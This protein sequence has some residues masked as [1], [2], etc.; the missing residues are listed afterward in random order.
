M[1]S[2]YGRRRRALDR[3]GAADSVG[4]LRDG[5]RHVREAAGR[6]AGSGGWN[7]RPELRH[8]EWGVVAL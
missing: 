2:V 7:P 6:R 8:K 3:G 5:R 1:Q 4:H